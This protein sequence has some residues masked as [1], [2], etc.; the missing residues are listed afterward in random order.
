M[1]SPPPPC[2]S[3]R[4]LHKERPRRAPPLSCS[5][6]MAHFCALGLPSSPESSWA[7]TSPSSVPS[8][9]PDP[10]GCWRTRAV[11]QLAG[12]R[13]H[14]SWQ[15][16]TS[17]AQWL[18]C[19]PHALG[20]RQR[21]HG[22]LLVRGHGERHNRLFGI[23]TSV[24]C[25]FQQANIFLGM[26]AICRKDCHMGKGGGGLILKVT[27][28]PFGK[29][30]Q[31]I[32]NTGCLLSPACRLLPGAGGHTAGAARGRASVGEAGPAWAGGRGGKLLLGG[33]RVGRETEETR[34]HGTAPSPVPTNPAN[35][36]GSPGLA[37]PS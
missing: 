6:Q 18:R 8:T 1:K 37:G 21:H 19:S 28:H 23:N 32:L 22:T 13:E 31:C 30:Q 11:A 29:K 16:G 2:T 15:K 9:D 3:L 27:A 36:A 34:V 35:S 26:P 25:F 14:T 17:E 4:H 33:F 24:T 5:I 12:P 10:C 7:G 20:C